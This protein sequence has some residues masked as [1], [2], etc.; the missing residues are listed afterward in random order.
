MKAS[1]I[2]RQKVLRIF[3]GSRCR[4]EGMLYVVRDSDGFIIGARSSSAAAWA[5][6]ARSP[7]TRAKEKN[8]G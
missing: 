7:R 8:R 6:A 3:P 1:T 2:L 5:A 4:K